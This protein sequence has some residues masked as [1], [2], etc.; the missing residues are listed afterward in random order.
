[1]TKKTVLFPHRCQNAGWWLICGWLAWIVITLI[2]RLSHVPMPNMPE[3][4]QITLF[5]LF[6]FMPTVGTLLIC[7]SQEK[8]EDEYIEHIRARSVF[9][10]V[11]II[12]STLLIDCSLTNIGSKLWMWS[13][14][15]GYLM[16]SWLYTNPFI[17]TMVYL[18]IFKGTLFVNWIKTRN[19]G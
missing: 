16:M 2:T 4:T 9:V 15:N 13:P 19:D 3:W 10:M 1:M 18:A 6:S 14:R 8:D 12:F 17:L 5:T 11:I 7:L